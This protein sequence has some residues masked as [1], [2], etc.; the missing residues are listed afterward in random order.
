MELYNTNNLL[1]I[2]LISSQ[3]LSKLV[4]VIYTG[5]KSVI[6]HTYHTE[7]SS[8]PLTAWFYFCHQPCIMKSSTIFWSVQ[9]YIMAVSVFP[10]T[11][12]QQHIIQ[13]CKTW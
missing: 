10:W 1:I 13:Y 3:T 11:Q 9:F 6:P 12:A 2:I 5:H 7:K 8:K 4:F